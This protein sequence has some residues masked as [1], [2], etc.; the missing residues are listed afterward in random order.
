MVKIEVPS[1]PHTHSCIGKNLIAFRAKKK[2]L[3]LKI[4]EKIMTFEDTGLNILLRLIGH[5]FTLH[6]RSTEGHTH[7]HTHTHKLLKAVKPDMV[8]WWRPK[9]TA[10]C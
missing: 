6:L 8:G 2:K 1:V 5:G 7:T 4:I 9:D 10:P 3:I